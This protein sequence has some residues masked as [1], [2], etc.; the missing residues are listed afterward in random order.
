MHRPGGPSVAAR[1]PY[2]RKARRSESEKKVYCQKRVRDVIVGRARSQVMQGPLAAARA[3][4]WIS[5][6]GLRKHATLQHLDVSHGRY[7]F[8]LFYFLALSL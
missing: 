2:K 3:E 8:R 1:A 7:I 6:W 5:P 4:K